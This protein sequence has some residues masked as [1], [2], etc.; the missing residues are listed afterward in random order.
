[1]GGLSIGEW[2][3]VIG[4]GITVGGAFVTAMVKLAVTQRETALLIKQMRC[5]V[6]EAHARIE[7]LEAKVFNVPGLAGA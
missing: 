4:L 7:R 6:R 3:T 1:M 2:A 5:E